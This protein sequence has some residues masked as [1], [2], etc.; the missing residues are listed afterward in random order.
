MTDATY[1]ELE[2]LVKRGDVAG[3]AARLGGILAADPDDDVAQ[4][5]HGTCAQ[6]LGDDAEFGRVHAELQA[7]M[8]AVAAYGEQSRRTALWEKYKALAAKLAFPCAMVASSV[9]LC[10]CYGC[11]PMDP[12]YRDARDARVVPASASDA[13]APVSGAPD[14]KKDD[15][16]DGGAPVPGV[17]AK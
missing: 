12:E 13:P 9:I 7:K 6:L 14:R 1:A 3:A 5:L 10:G 4:M 15:D 16:L 17:P 2:E 8:D 11:P